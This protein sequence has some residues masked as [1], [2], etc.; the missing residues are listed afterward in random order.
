M[1]VTLNGLSSNE[2]LV[3]DLMT[4]GPITLQPYSSLKDAMELMEWRRIRHLPV[5]NSG[6]EILGLLSHRDCLNL[7]FSE[8]SE[9]SEEDAK[10]IYETIPV[11]EVMKRELITTTPYQSLKQAAQILFEYKIGC[12]PVID[13]HNRL[14]GI[15]TEAD[16]VKA[17]AQ[18]PSLTVM[19]PSSQERIDDLEA[20]R[21]SV[22]G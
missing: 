15:L 11:N 20:K 5:V 4:A 2:V 6:G 3:R 8:L 9:V 21:L 13:S 1:S 22:L 18:W 14:L 10:E 12:L 16:F 17:V 7:S 19:Q